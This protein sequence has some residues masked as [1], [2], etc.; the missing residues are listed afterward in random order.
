MEAFLLEKIGDLLGRGVLAH[1]G[2]V[3]P[4]AFTKECLHFFRRGG[5][6]GFR[7]RL[8]ILITE[9]IDQFLQARRIEESIDAQIAFV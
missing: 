3:H 1:V 7:I 2:E 4:P 5:P 6:I 9:Q 8:R